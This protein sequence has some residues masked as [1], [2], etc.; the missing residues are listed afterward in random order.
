MFHNKQTKSWATKEKN[1]VSIHMKKLFLKALKD[2]ISIIYYEWCNQCSNTLVV[3]FLVILNYIPSHISQ[4]LNIKLHVNK[5][6]IKTTCWYI[7]LFEV[8][9]LVL[10]SPFLIIFFYCPNKQPQKAQWD[11]IILIFF[12][13][14]VQ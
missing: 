10:C 1:D 13:S 12:N 3:F 11:F 7:F 6:F 9:F 8:P 4:F 5:L 2:F 14:K